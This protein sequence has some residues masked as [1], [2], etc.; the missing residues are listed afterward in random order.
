MR[1]RYK[2][3]RTSIHIRFRN[4]PE[5]RKTF[6]ACQK[7]RKR[8]KAATTKQKKVS[9]SRKERKNVNLL[10]QETQIIFAFCYQFLFLRA[11]HSEL[12]TF[13]CLF[14]LLLISIFIYLIC[15]IS[16][17]HLYVKSV[18]NFILNL[19]FNFSQNRFL[20]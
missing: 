14:S 8:K 12:L 13:I 4:C 7:T 2:L 5:R 3:D 9:F 6:S 15:S 19:I 11:G 10:I 16:C 17:L 1:K 20:F 18:S